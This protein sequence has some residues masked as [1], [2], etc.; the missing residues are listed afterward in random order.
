[1]GKGFEQGRKTHPVFWVLAGVLGTIA[2]GAALSFSPIIFRK[3]P[4]PQHVTED[5]SATTQVTPPLP[6]VPPVTTPPEIP[7]AAPVAAEPPKEIPDRI[8]TTPDEVVKAYI[9]AKRWEDRLPCLLDPKGVR[10]MMAIRYKNADLS[11]GMTRFLPATLT[12]EKGSGASPIVRV[13]VRESMPYH[14]YLRYAVVKSDLG[15][16]VDWLESL[17]MEDEANE[18]A[19]VNKLG[20]ST[21]VLEVKIVKKYQASSSYAAYDLK[22]V[23]RS[24]KM[25]TYWSIEASV[26]D[27]DGAYLGKA[28]KNGTNLKAGF[29]VFSAI[30]LEGMKYPTIASWKPQIGDI[31]IEVSSGV[32]A[33]ATKHFTLK[34]VN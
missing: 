27:R 29:E 30:L 28:M 14:Q 25:L 21:P 19:E 34:E 8:F 1:M 10:Q 24:N 33:Q 3:Q 4:S 6:A 13:D 31:Q 23:N 22:V 20:L 2:A 11:G 15:Y 32:Q 18:Q 17:K 12:T 7:P 9:S 5:T 16:K 26:Y